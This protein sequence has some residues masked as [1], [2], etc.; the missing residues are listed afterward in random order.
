[1]TEADL[2]RI[3]QALGITLPKEYREA[4]L[5]PALAPAEDNGPGLCGDA[6][7]LIRDNTAL[8]ADGFYGQ[9]WAPTHFVIQN[10]GCGN[11]YFITCPYNNTVYFADH[12]NTFD[13]DHLSNLRQWDSFYE[14]RFA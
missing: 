6:E 4:V 5:D 8:L 3:E 2:N 13:C 1:M 14:L 11:F 12:E 10:D 7:S 9:K